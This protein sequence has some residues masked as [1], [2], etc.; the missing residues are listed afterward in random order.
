MEVSLWEW[1]EHISRASGKK[2]LRVDYYGAL[3]DPPISEYLTIT[4]EGWAGAKAVSLLA[5]IASKSK[6]VIFRE[7]YNAIISNDLHPIVDLINQATPPKLIEYKKNGKY[8]Q[9]IK[10]EWNEA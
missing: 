9:I 3:S 1:R 10:R 5:D 8:N 7:I 4:H 2:M 6:A